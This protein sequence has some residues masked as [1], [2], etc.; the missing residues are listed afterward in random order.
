MTRRLA[1]RRCRI[2]VVTGSRAEYGLLHSTISA[3]ARHPKLT[4]QLVVTG[5]HLLKRFGY[6]VDDIVR[7]GW[8]ID[9]RIPMQRGTDGPTDQAAGLARGLAGIATFLND[10]NTDI[11]VVLGDLIEAMAGALATV[12]TG[13]C[14]AHIHGGDVAVGDF[15]ES[16]RHAITKLA[17][18]HF[19]ATRSAARRIIR[20]GE[21]ESNVHCVGA[22]GIDDL[23]ALV[24]TYG[25]KPKRTHRALILFHASGR[26]PDKEQRTM[27]AIIKATSHAGLSKTIIHPNSDRGH[28]GIIRAIEQHARETRGDAVEVF[29][30]LPREDYLLRLIEAD[31]LI[32]NSSSGI[33]EAATAG[34]PVVNVGNRQAGRQRAGRS[35]IDCPETTSSIETALNRALKLRPIMGA[36]TAYGDGTAGVRIAEILAQRGCGDPLPRKRCTY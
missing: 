20:M 5:M 24:R 25:K 31:L 13:R 11:V 4:L 16:L 36:R 32:G 2:A 27:S 1:R 9:A 30:S 35:V 28:R 8:T 22:P 33:I 18:L 23:A 34:T 7:D 29:R 6:T 10:A 19:P 12:T 21:P 14:V 17:H 26:S 3:I 15:D